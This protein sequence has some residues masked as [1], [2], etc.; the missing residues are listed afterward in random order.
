MQGLVVQCVKWITYAS[1][2]L[3]GLPINLLKEYKRQTRHSKECP[4]AT[5]NPCDWCQWKIYPSQSQP[6]TV[7]SLPHDVVNA[8]RTKQ[9]PRKKSLV[10]INIVVEIPANRTVNNLLSYRF[11]ADLSMSHIFLVNQI[12]ELRSLSTRATIA[13][14]I[15][16][17][18]YVQPSLC[19][20]N[21]T[22]PILT[23]IRLILTPCF[24]FAFSV[25]VE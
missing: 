17:I 3:A 18:A 1:S 8:S 12:Y 15:D 21:T 2:R 11:E 25:L 10:E 19:F 16:W 7:L 13:F 4:T 5:N 20:T 24:G 23:F 9:T 6:L 22:W 14:L